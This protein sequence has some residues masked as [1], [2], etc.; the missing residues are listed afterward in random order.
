MP[1]RGKANLELIQKLSDYFGI[2]KD[3]IRVI[4]GRTFNKKLVE[5][6]T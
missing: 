2:G 5:V 6:D 1:A 4:S 3:R